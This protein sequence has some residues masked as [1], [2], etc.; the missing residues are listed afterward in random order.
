MNISASYA[1]KLCPL[2]DVV[3]LFTKLLVCVQVS[4]SGVTT[5]PRPEELLQAYHSA[6]G[7]ATTVHIN[8]HVAY[9]SIEGIEPRPE[10]LQHERGLQANEAYDSTTGIGTLC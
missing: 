3:L 1:F 5:E 2:L 6:I 7:A 10:G 9:D 4:S 8:V